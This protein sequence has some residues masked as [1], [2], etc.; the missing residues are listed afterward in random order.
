MN[1]CAIRLPRDN[2]KWL[3]FKNHSM[4]ERVPFIIYADLECTLKKTEAD[5]ETSGIYQHH[6]VYSVGYYVRCSYD[7]SL[8][9]YRCRRDKDCITWFT[10]ELRRLAHNVKSILSTN[11]PMVDLTRDEWEKFNSATHCHV[12]EK[13]FAPDDTRVRDHCHLTGRYRGPAHSDC[14]LNYKNS[15]HIP[16]VFHNLSGYDSHFIINEIATAFE[17]RVDLLPITKEKYISFTKNVKS[18]E[19]KDMKTCIK[20]RFIDSY[21]FLSTSLEKLASFLNKNKLKIIRSKFS[22]LS[23]QDFELL[24]RKGVFPYEYIDCVEKLEDSCLPPRDSFYSSLTG[25]TVSESDYAHAVNVWQRFSI[26]TLGEY[27]DLYLKIDVLLLADIFENFRDSCVASYGLDPAHYYTLPGFTWDAMLKHTRINFELL[28]NID[29]VM[30]IERGIRGGLSQCSGRYA[31]ANNKYMQ[32][33]DPS[34]PSSYLM[35]FDVNNLYGWAMC[36]PLPYADFRWVNNISNF[37]VNA[38]ASDSPTGYILE[39]DLEYPQCLHDTHADLPFCPTSDKPPGKRV[40]KLLATLY[41]KERYVIHYRNLQQCT[42]HGLRVTKI[43][44]VLQ[45]TQSTWLRDY[46]ELN[47]KFR[48]QAKNDFE[49]NLYKLMNNAVFG[50]TME[51]VRNHVD[52]RLL[53]NWDGRY[54]AEVMIAKPNFHSRSVFSENLVAIEMRKLEIKFNK[55]IYVGMCILDIS[56]TCLYKFHH[57]YMLPLYRDKCK[58]MYTDTDSLIY[59]VECDDVYET[60]KRDI[61]KFDTSDYAI[62][63]AYDIP[64]ENKKVPGLM[65]DENNGAIMTEFVGLRAKMY[66]LKVDGKKDTKK[67]KGVKSNVVARTITFDDY[68]RCLKDEIEMTRQQF[69][70]RSKLHEVHT[71]RETKIALSPYDDKRYVIPDSIDTLPWGHYQIPPPKT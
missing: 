14:N 53:T 35:Y 27:S 6:E 26:Q 31:Q 38:I 63:N 29:M 23:D 61:D 5:P 43:H 18:T 67:A 15:Y 40:N 64:L 17:G 19:D 47:T 71:I 52:V 49:K 34:K 65:K 51:N 68:T 25:D 45:F 24:T 44:R 66:A 56:K 62:D 42:R 7:D 48:T 60:M 21:K 16:I 22:A 37:D 50:K 4:K 57:E 11:I 30:F 58:V 54:G 59:H 28:T 9:A 12:C 46:I 8:S 39:V 36:Q 32:S 70:I 55:P 33:H 41:N 2:D 20:L 69:C 10:E 3:S 13:P 1:N